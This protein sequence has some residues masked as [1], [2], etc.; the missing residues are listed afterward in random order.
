M[1]LNC[2]LDD[3]ILSNLNNFRFHT[4]WRQVWCYLIE[5]CLLD[6]LF[7]LFVC[8][9]YIFGLL[10]RGSWFLIGSA[11]YSFSSFWPWQWVWQFTESRTGKYKS[12]LRY[13]KDVT[14]N[15][16]RYNCNETSIR[17][18]VCQRENKIG[19]PEMRGMRVKKDRKRVLTIFGK[20]RKQL[21]PSNSVFII[22]TG[23]IHFV[24]CVDFYLKY[25]MC[26]GGK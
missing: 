11:V 2:P 20:L 13:A 24:F 8:T 18:W 22:W 15:K 4:S 21:P 3:V 1:K 16:T 25:F 5:L 17:R 14:L 9:L 7:S 23:L 19:L 12:L 26:R 10:L 6:Y